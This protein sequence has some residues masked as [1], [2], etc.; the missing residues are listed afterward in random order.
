MLIT[1]FIGMSLAHGAEEE[2]HGE[3]VVNNH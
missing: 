2:A 3:K 1:V